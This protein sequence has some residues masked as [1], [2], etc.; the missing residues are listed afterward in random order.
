MLLEDAQQ[1]L[2]GRLTPDSEIELI[3]WQEKPGGEDFHDRFVL[4]G[5][6]GIMV[7]AGLS[8]AGANECGF[9]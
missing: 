6:A 8:A 9:R 3:E 4:S 7:G 1:R 5:T 2:R